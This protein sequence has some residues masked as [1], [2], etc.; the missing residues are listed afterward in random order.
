MKYLIF[1]FLLFSTLYSQK[2]VLGKFEK[3][4]LNQF[5]LKNLKAKIDTGAKTSS[6]HCS[7]IQKISGNKVAF[8]ILDDEHIKFKPISYISDISRIGKV[9]SSNGKVQ[10][11]YFIKTPVTILGKKYITE[12]SLTNRGNM[13]FPV[14]IGRSLLKRDFCIDVTKEYTGDNNDRLPKNP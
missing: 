5:G 4:T 8:T 3:V 7:F 2:I 6:L 1:V 9:K 13:K 14:L 12:F 10:K 11:R